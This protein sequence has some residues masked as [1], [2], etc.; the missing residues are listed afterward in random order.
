MKIDK[1]AFNKL[2]Y[3]YYG[4][5]QY[6]PLYNHERLNFGVAIF[7]FEPRNKSFDEDSLKLFAEE[8]VGSAR[9]D[10]FKDYFDNPV[11]INKKFVRSKVMVLDDF[12]RI[13]RAY[14][15]S[16]LHKFTVDG[17]TTRISDLRSYAE[18]QHFMNTRANSIFISKLGIIKYS[19]IDVALGEIFYQSV[20]I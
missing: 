17:I 1:S 3:G 20:N 10:E 6:C 15:N 9:Y 12:D 16:T 13:N 11:D 19:D 18:I 7:E 2:L 14:K 8:R 5:L 4:Y